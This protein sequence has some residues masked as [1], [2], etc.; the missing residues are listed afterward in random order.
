[1]VQGRLLRE[2]D[3]KGSGILNGHA[4]DRDDI[5][6]FLISIGGPSLILEGL[7]A[8]ILMRAQLCTIRT[9]IHAMQLAMVI[10]FILLAFILLLRH[11]G[12]FSS[13][14]HSNDQ[15]LHTDFHLGPLTRG[16]FDRQGPLRNKPALVFLHLNTTSIGVP[17]FVL[18]SFW[19][20]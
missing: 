14:T 19:L 7:R 12:P 4:H 15:G 16:L 8:H 11:H 1:M 10:H 5:L 13:Q 6:Q 3:C 9:T 2:I 20:S 17:F 18:D